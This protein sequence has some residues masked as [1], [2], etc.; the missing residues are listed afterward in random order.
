MVPL[1]APDFAPA[2]LELDES[3]GPISVGVQ[4]AP[5]LANT[6]GHIFNKVD[7]VLPFGSFGDLTTSSRY[8]TAE[9]SF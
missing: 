5:Y 4:A 1:I 9:K 8:I 2:A 7:K 3:P 6:A